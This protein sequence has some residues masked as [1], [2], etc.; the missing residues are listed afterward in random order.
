MKPHPPQLG[1]LT[2]LSAVLAF[3]PLRA[4]LLLQ[5]AHSG[6]NTLLTWTNPAAALEHSLALANAWN[7]VTGVLSPSL[8][9]AI[10]VASFHRLRLSTVGPFDFRYLAPTFTR[11]LADPGGCGCTSAMNERHRNHQLRLGS[12]PAGKINPQTKRNRP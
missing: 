12:N 9:P 3:T 10:S 6:S 11:G 2:L 1:K 4:H 5:I 8:V 7:E